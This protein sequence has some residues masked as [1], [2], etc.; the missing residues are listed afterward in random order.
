MRIRWRKE[1]QNEK[2]WKVGKEW[3]EWNKGRKEKD[4][5]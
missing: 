1:W 3:K 4:R 5:K 2:D